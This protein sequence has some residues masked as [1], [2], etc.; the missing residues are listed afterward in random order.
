MTQFAA[1]RSSAT[2]KWRNSPLAEALQQ[3]NDTIYRLQNLCKLTNKTNPYENQ[4]I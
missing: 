4:K 3:E 2:G 1:C